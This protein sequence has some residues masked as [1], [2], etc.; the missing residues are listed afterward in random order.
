MSHHTTSDDARIT[1]RC[2]GHICFQG[3]L[4]DH[5]RWGT[6]SLPIVEG[7]TAS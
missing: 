7:R 1:V 5:Q 2:V 6:D 4:E 3:T